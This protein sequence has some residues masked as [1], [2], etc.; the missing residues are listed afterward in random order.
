MNS[1]KAYAH[2]SI[3]GA[4]LIVSPLGNIAVT[5]ECMFKTTATPAEGAQEITWDITAQAIVDNAKNNAE[6]LLHPSACLIM[7]MFTQ[8]K[9]EDAASE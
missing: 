5:N 1:Q 7:A 4:L 9:I 8:E 2:P 3:S 6:N